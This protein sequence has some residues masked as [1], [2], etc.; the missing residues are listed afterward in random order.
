MF[1]IHKGEEIRAFFMLAHIF[2]VIS[3]LMIIKPVSHA[4]FLSQFGVKQLPFVFILVAGFA[5][6]VSRIYGKILGKINFLTLILQTL[7]IF[8]LLLL[9]IW[10]FLTFQI[11][12]NIILYIFFISVSLFAVIA[13][14]QF[15]ILAN[16]IFNPRE[17]RRLFGFIGAG[18][19]AGGILGGYITKLF[20]P[21]IGSENLILV[22]AALLF[23]CDPIIKRVWQENPAV[24]DI[25]NIGQ[26]SGV[27]EKTDIPLK[28]IRSNR[29]LYY[30]A[31]IVL[32]S[33]SVAKFVDYE[34]N[35]IASDRIHDEEQLA[36]FLGFWYSNLNVISLLIQLFIT[37]QVVGV[38]GV[39]SSLLFLPLTLLIGAA[40]VLIHPGLPA[41]IFL[42]MGDG[43]L[44]NSVQKSGIELLSLPIPAEIRNPARS[45]I[46]VFGDSFATG[47]S[48]LILM[49]LTVILN[50]PVRFIS[51]IIVILVLVWLYYVKQVKYEY[52]R[53]F[54]RKIEPDITKASKK[55]MDLKNASVIG[56]IIK[57]LNGKR[58]TR[59]IE[60]LKMVRV[61]RNDRLV[62]CFKKLLVHPSSQVKLETL[63]N[64]YFYTDNFTEKIAPMIF[65]PHP[66]V[67]TE[68]LHYLFRLEQEDPTN[69]M[70]IYLNHSNES[71]RYAALL[72]AT[73]ESRNNSTLKDLFKIQERIE[74][75][76]QQLKKFR[77]DE[78]EIQKSMC[79]QMI[80]IA[81]IPELHP[82]LHIFL[83]DS[84]S[85]VIRKALLAAGQTKD[86]TFL[87][88]LMR[89]LIDPQFE[90]CAIE[91]L[92]FF[93][94]D[95]LSL[96]VRWMTDVKEDRMI[97]LRMPEIIANNGTQR[98]AD[99]LVEYIENNDSEIRHKIILALNHLRRRHPELKF[100]DK[101]IVHRILEEAQLY[102]QTLAVLYAQVKKGSSI[103]YPNNTGIHIHKARKKLI[104]LLEKKLDHTLEI[105]FKL[106]GL[107]YPPE[108]IDYA[109]TGVRSQKLDIRMNTLEF[110]DN[111][112]DGPIKRTVIPIV[113][114]AFIEN[115]V[116]RTLDQFGLP[117]P[118]EFECFTTLLVD[119][120]PQVQ[121]VTLSL[122]GALKSEEYMPQ[123]C[124]LLNHK[125]KEVQ[126]KAE[127]T[128]KHIGVI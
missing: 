37:R 109:F 56:S 124:T 123:V 33:V 86:R 13:T 111:L 12:E 110:L 68:A 75:C 76:L 52:I 78:G 66:D 87:P 58:E 74:N 106:M 24:R 121:L 26:Q 57:I 48:G 81:R 43:S 7:R 112:L 125:N 92:S 108:D 105:I 128:L 2:L 98:A 102:N 27:F 41:A 83:R 97:R 14:S 99:M 63:R 4:Q 45:Y 101:R 72:C 38:F 39:G 60:A 54:R 9:L 82:F 53:T 89:R 118:S 17:A 36:A 49:V 94:T 96:F 34:F 85:T 120:D 6:V 62:P 114:S 50:I 70:R 22:G 73:R 55:D 103:N 65:D 1:H 115:L 61:I 5:A 77:S 19:I 30:L 3:A 122:I 127:R 116:E 18:A 126:K 91:A 32:L 71:I 88:I 25:K 64:L 11:C 107:K 44:K 95:V 79:V 23:L 21:M 51:L 15:W 119:E 28:M 20:V 113:E 40:A 69:L 117:V 29:H 8:I 80:G 59:I 104:E 10:G 42:K 35:A 93:D 90:S 67:Q 31:A 16:I 47:I 100:D 84:S 46:D